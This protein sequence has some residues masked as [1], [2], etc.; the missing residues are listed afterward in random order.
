MRECLTVQRKR[1]CHEA[2]DAHPLPRFLPL[3]SKEADLS[4]CT[5]IIGIDLSFPPH[6][7]QNI[8][9]LL[10]QYTMV[11]T[12]AEGM[13]FSIR[14][15]QYDGEIE[16]FHGKGDGY[17][18]DSCGGTCQIRSARQRVSCP[19]ACSDEVLSK[20]EISIIIRQS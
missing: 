4:D 10:E 8:I 16:L 9:H 18:A 12:Q 3:K 7:E 15:T 1:K 14:N 2:A 6:K 19:P 17:F 20:H 13:A 5:L 11:D